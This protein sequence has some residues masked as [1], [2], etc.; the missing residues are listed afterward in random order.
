MHVVV[1][2]QQRPDN[3]C[4]LLGLRLLRLFFGLVAL[5]TAFAFRVVWIQLIGA[6]VLSRLMGL[7][8]WISLV[9]V[10]IHAVFVGLA[11]RVHLFRVVISVCL[12]LVLHHSNAV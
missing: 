3:E 5:A 4:S 8:V 12:L 11:R 10:I 6:V 1:T 9:R 7:A 2:R